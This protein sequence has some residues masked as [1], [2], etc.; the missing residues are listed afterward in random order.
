MVK[1][2]SQ[3]VPVTLPSDQATATT[4]GMKF[5]K[6]E[7]LRIIQWNADALSTKIDELRSRIP[8]EN[9]D[10]LHDTGHEAEGEN[11]DTI[12]QKI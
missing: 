5:T 2:S 1:I 4:A 11:E 7:S 9:I 12:Y 6:N 10:V 8:E 3:A